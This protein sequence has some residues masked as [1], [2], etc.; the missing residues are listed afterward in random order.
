MK[1]FVR[2]AAIGAVAAVAFGATI[3]V[4]AAWSA[5]GS[6]TGSAKALHAQGVTAAAGS[7]AADLYPGGTGTLYYTLTNPNPYGITFSS[8]TFGTV[9]SSDS[10]N[11]PATNVTASTATLNLTTSPVTVAAGASGVAGSFAGTITMS[12]S[13]PDGCQGVTFTVPITLTGTQV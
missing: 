6:G 11:C 7:G 10:V 4:Y 12:H 5:A 9:V 8:V 13:A 1:G 3:V 2:A